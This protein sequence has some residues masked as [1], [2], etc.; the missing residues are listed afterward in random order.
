[1]SRNGGYLVLGVFFGFVLSQA[2]ASEFDAIHG[3][4]SGTDLSLAWVMLTAII[5]GHLGMQWVSRKRVTV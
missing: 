5:V 1:M 4:F 3:M 2:R